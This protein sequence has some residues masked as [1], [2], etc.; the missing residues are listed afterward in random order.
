MKPAVYKDRVFTTAQRCGYA[1]VCAYCG[2]TLTRAEATV[3]HR[4][5]KARAGGNDRENFTIACSDC[6]TKKGKSVKLADA[7]LIPLTIFARANWC[8]VEIDYGS[9]ASDIM[10]QRN[11]KKHFCGTKSFGECDSLNR[12]AV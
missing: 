7:Y 9:L 1:V 4:I 11:K 3:D 10:P 5:P 6:N 2:T 8:F 12:P